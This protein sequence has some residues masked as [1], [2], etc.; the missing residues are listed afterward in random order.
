MVI[1][2]ILDKKGNDV[3]SLDLRKIRD[4]VSEFLIITH[5]DSNT[6]V[7]A[8]C[9]SVLKETYE[10]GFQV[11]HTEGQKNGEWIIIDFVDITVHIFYRDKRDFY[12]L[13]DLWND[14]KLTKHEE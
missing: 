13:E 10:A 3:V 7:K 6:H 14:A 11:Y 4:T 9:D 12:A 8:I 5:G 2:A 1:D